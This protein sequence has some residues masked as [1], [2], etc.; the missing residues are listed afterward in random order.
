[1]GKIIKCY[2][3]SLGHHINM[4]PIDYILNIEKI[5]FFTAFNCLEYL[6]VKIDFCL[7]KVLN[8]I[9]IKEKKETNNFEMV[10]WAD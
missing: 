3:Y 10:F 7:I 8:S 4:I 6:F 2:H 9:A 1:M 5:D